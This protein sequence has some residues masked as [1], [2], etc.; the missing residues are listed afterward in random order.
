MMEIPRISIVVPVYN[1][2]EIIRELYTRVCGSLQTISFELILVNDGSSDNSWEEISKLAETDARV[3]GIDLRYNSGQDNA[4]MSGI[5][6]S[7]GTTVVIMD[8]D[9]QHDPADILALYEKC[10]EGYDV[11]FADFKDWTQ[12]ALRKTG[13]RVNG[14]FARWLL[15]KPRGMYLSPFKILSRQIADEVCRFIGPYPY[16]DG[17]ILTLTTRIGNIVVTHHKRFS[18]H[19]NYNMRRAAGVW[20]KLFTGFSVAP[21]RIAALTGLIIAVTGL[22]LMVYYLCEYFFTSHIVEG[23]TTMVLLLLFF[24]GLILMILGLLGEYIGRIYL[25]LNGK[26]QYSIRTIVKASEQK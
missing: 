9:L 26:P 25:T 16:I 18:G 4:I 7:R 1:S 22:G 23:W 12:S 19:S 5:R 2:S 17:I 8:D 15:G 11:V 6:E 10:R 13:S 24:G 14:S 20:F 21:L 3:T